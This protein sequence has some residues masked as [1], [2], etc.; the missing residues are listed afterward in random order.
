MLLTTTTREALYS[1]HCYWVSGWVTV[2]VGLA[3]VWKGLRL[4]LR[5]ALGR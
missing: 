1:A 3:V 5:V 2:R 4:Y